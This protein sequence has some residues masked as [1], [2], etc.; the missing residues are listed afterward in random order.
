MLIK[1]SNLFKM[2]DKMTQLSIIKTFKL[3]IILLGKYL[4][5]ITLFN[6]RFLLILFIIILLENPVLAR[7]TEFPDLFFS[8]GQIMK[9][10]SE[11]YSGNKI[12]NRRNKK[13]KSREV[14]V[15]IASYKNILETEYG[16]SVQDEIVKAA[17]IASRRTC[18]TLN[19]SSIKYDFLSES[20]KLDLSK[21]QLRESTIVFLIST[22]EDYFFAHGRS[23]VGYIYAPE[24]EVENIYDRVFIETHQTTFD[25]NQY[26]VIIRSTRI[27]SKRFENLRVASGIYR[28]FNLSQ[29][30]GR[31]GAGECSAR[32]AV[33]R[34]MFN[35]EIYLKETWEDSLSVYLSRTQSDEMKK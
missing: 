11:L 10:I 14:H 2:I 28:T 4:V 1:R 34:F 16:R 13:P 30:C 24:F 21:M 3:T 25:Q 7:C 27:P 9:E 29:G 15:Y 8:Q 35:E 6:Y 32:E 19:I 17:N 5:N 20:K 31:Y 12:T 18:S 33:W 22:F 23:S 26:F